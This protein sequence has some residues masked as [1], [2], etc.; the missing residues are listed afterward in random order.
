MD[1]DLTEPALAVPSGSRLAGGHWMGLARAVGHNVYLVHL[2]L[3]GCGAG[4]AEARLVSFAIARSRTL[5][6]VSLRAN[7]IGDLG[8]R[9]LSYVRLLLLFP[10]ATRPTHSPRLS[11]TRSWPTW[12]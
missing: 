7:A 10:S 4:D 12:S 3:D 11:G 6:T 1:H 9:T 5:A 2:A 8:A